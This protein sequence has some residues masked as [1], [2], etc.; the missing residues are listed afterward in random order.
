MCKE[1]AILVCLKKQIY[2]LSI[3]N[4]KVVIALNQNDIVTPVL[5]RNATRCMNGSP[6]S[7]KAT[8]FFLNRHMVTNDT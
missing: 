6:R 3:L 8:T 5:H 2:V 1:L 4:R 7:V